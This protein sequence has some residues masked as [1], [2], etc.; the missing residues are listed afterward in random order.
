MRDAEFAATLHRQIEA[1]PFV[2]EVR[3]NAIAGSLIIQYR[4][5][6]IAPEI[7]EDKLGVCIQEAIG[8]RRT[9]GLEYSD[10]TLDD[11]DLIPLVNQWKDLGMSSLALGAAILAAP[12][13][14]P[15]LL[16]GGLVAGATLPWVTRAADSLATQGHGNIDLLDS[17][18]MLLQ[19]VRG[20]FAAPALKAVLVEL[21]RTLRGTTVQRREAAAQALLNAPEGTVLLELDGQFYPVP[22][23]RV[24]VGDRLYC[25]AGQTIPADGW[26]LQGKGVLDCQVLIGSAHPIP[27]APPQEVYA[28]SMLLEGELWIQVNRTGENTRMGLVAR[29]MLSTP[30]HDTQVGL[31]QAELLKQA[32]FPTL[33]LGG[34]IF[35]ATG[36]VGAA[37]SP[38]QFDFGSGVPITIATTLL[39]ALTHAARNGVYIRTGR[40]LEALAQ[41]N[42]V[43]LDQSILGS[44][45]V[46]METQE[47]IAA[48][49][50]QHLT[51]YLLGH[52]DATTTEAVAHACQ[53]PLHQTLIE[54]TAAQKTQLIQAL[55]HQG[56]TVV[57][58][59]DRQH[60]HP[61]LDHADVS[62]VFAET[63]AIAHETADVV[64]MMSDMRGVLYARAI[65]Q[66][67]ME[68]LYQNTAMIT[69]PNLLM[70][71]GGG[72]IIGVSPVYNVIVNN[73]SALIAEF[74][75]GNHPHFNSIPPVPATPKPLPAL[76]ENTLNTPLSLPLK[77]RDLADRLGSTT[78][79][80][81]H[82]RLKPDFT[83][84]S[85]AKDPE[86]K[87]WR[88]DAELRVFVADPA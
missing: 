25:C 85:R 31:R 13:E 15:P 47:A 57:M 29:L 35:V 80:L 76:P 30:V 88:Y 17:T 56:K 27:C 9:E 33:L 71:I 11:E 8:I 53:I 26:V 2:T 83:E 10:P 46:L 28:T 34:A 40:A 19:T 5:R 42:V 22:L 75:N 81:T 37:L 84:W 55:R 36:N 65:A 62:V 20:Q 77:Q 43:V 79:A 12:L 38:Y 16:V 41:A 67:A 64:I 72:M 73:S 60:C 51:L 3:L 74:L 78:Q 1:F 54:T 45:S 21:R 82:H 59:G 70:Q 39:A 68:V 32:I 50:D 7:L 63:D 6:A 52:G 44:D 18:W 49:R 14:L 48:L 4:S 24:T 86:G 23:S 66:Q 87:A 61:E 58:V 69:I